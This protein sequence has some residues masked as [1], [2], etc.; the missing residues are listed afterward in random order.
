M[1]IKKKI[2]FIIST[3]ALALV[4]TFGFSG[5]AWAAG[6]TANPTNIQLA[7]MTYSGEVYLKSGSINSGFVKIWNGPSPE[8]I[9][10]SQNG[11]AI[12][13]VSGNLY[14]TRLPIGGSWTKVSDSV[15]EGNFAI[16]NN[17]V[18][19]LKNQKLYYKPLSNLN[20]GWTEV[21]SG[22][23]GFKVAQ[24]GNV[25]VKSGSTLYVAYGGYGAAWTPVATNF[26]SYDVS[27][28]LVAAVI[29]GTA[30][31]KNAPGAGW[32]TTYSGAQSVQMSADNNLAVVDNGG[33]LNVASNGYGSTWTTTVRQAGDFQN[34]QITD[35]I[36]GVV[37]TSTLYVKS[38]GTTA[39]WTQ[40]ASPV[41]KFTAN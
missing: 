2:T 39:Q 22:V 33:N 41:K 30:F 34:E 8:D 40:V 18:H 31:V 26:S 23:S 19:W 10:V 28:S 14:V 13:D 36:I 4:I 32:N 27:N 35:S 20:A 29:G 6:F 38:G 9:D 24:N 17:S 25:A 3:F 37:H 15:S 1:G 21:M 11:M 16:S 12:L 5:A 7:F